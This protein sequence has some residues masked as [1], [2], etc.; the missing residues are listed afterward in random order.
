MVEQ[1]VKHDVTY[2]GMK[3]GLCVTTPDYI[4]GQTLVTVKQGVFDARM[5]SFTTR[6]FFYK[7]WYSRNIN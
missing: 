4:R 6:K 5:V 3:R 2:S 1:I 7:G